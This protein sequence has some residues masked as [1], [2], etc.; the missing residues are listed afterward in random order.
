MKI[1]CINGDHYQLPTQ[2][3]E[4]NREQFLAICRLSLEAQA[5][6][7]IK[8]KVLFLL[9]GFRIERMKEQRI[10]D[11][12][13]FYVSAGKKHVY[14]LAATDVAYLANKMDFI[15]RITEDDEG[16]KSYQ[17]RSRLFRQLLPDIK[18]KDGILYGP[19]D[20]LNNLLFSEFVVAENHYAGFIKSQETEAGSEKKTEKPQPLK[21]GAITHYCDKLIATL[22]RPRRRDYDENIPE[23]AADGREV[24][25]VGTAEKREKLVRSLNPEVKQ[26]ILFWYEG[27]KDFLRGKFPH[28][29]EVQGESEKV[30]GNSRLRSNEQSVFEGYVK[31]ITSLAK[32]DATKVDAWM[33]TNLYGVLIAME[34]MRLEQIEM[35]KLYKK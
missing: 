27:C 7:E 32:N 34:N 11:E 23:H 29:F 24:M 13:C 30:K 15:F 28:V 22:Y 4:L 17:F 5:V 25:N 3:N 1:V 19:A 9:L 35:D 16:N 20:G 18:L 21:E 31:M 6:T 26:G 33:N 14:L 2:W 8:A 10:G 12:E